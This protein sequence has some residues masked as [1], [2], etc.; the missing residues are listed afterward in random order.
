MLNHVA[1]LLVPF[2][3]PQTGETEERQVRSNLRK[4]SVFFFRCLNSEFS[5]ETLQDTSS[6]IFNSAVDSARFVNFTHSFFCTAD[7]E[8]ISCHCFMISRNEFEIVR[9]SILIQIAK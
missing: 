7:W 2:T 8:D 9:L 1:A 6:A 5:C 4:A 3:D